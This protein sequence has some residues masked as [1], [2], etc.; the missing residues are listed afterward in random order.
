MKRG[1]VSSPLVF[2]LVWTLSALINKET[3]TFL[4]RIHNSARQEGS[5]LSF[6]IFQPFNKKKR[7]QRNQHIQPKTGVSVWY[8]S[9]WDITHPVHHPFLPPPSSSSS[10]SFSHLP[11]MKAVIVYSLFLNKCRVFFSSKCLL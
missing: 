2:S 9:R 4:P 5:Y 3:P 10:P 8:F 1:S 11:N 6:F 7:K